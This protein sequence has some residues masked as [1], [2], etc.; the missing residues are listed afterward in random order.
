MSD[1]FITGT[2][3]GVG[4]TWVT[5][6]LMKAMQNKGKVVVGMKPVASGCQKISGVLRNDDAVQ[7]LKQSSKRPSQT[8]DYK[9]VNP[10]AFEQAIAPHIAADLAG[11]VIDI[12]K[13]A[14]EFSTLKKNSDSVVVEGVGGWCVPLGD[15]VM[16]SDLVNRLGLPVIL[17]VGLR[18]G[19]INHALT[20]VRAVEVGGAK[21]RGWIASQLDPDYVCLEE[22]MTTLKTR[23]SAPLLGSLPYMESF[24][25][26]IAASQLVI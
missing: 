2:D 14:D 23:I 11:V 12:G 6:A 3:T 19:C 20:T 21:L 5:L 24:D 17:V 22:T 1:Y 8:L 26:E 4:K 7:I 25:A 13:I 16:L 10:Y 18:L 9:T 15:N